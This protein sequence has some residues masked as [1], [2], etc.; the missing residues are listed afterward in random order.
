MTL[1]FMLTTMCAL[2]CVQMEETSSA[3]RKISLAPLKLFAF[4]INDLLTD[5][6]DGLPINA[7][8][9]SYK[10][11]FGREINISRLGFPKLIKVLE[12]ITNT[13][14]VSD[15]ALFCMVPLLNCSVRDEL[16]SSL[17]I[18]GSGAARTIHRKAYPEV[19]A[20]KGG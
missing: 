12:A 16:A 14:D 2:L 8:V 9:P 17:Q 7:V 18:R 13:I 3:Q 11:K 19:M 10:D 6:P 5:R 15:D 1:H 20:L 4:E